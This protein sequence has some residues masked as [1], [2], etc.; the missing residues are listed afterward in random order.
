MAAHRHSPA[1]PPDV[2]VRIRRFGWLRLARKS[3]YSDSVV[4][5]GIETDMHEQGRVVPPPACV[6]R[7]FC[8][9]VLIYAEF[10]QFG[11]GLGAAF[12]LFELQR[13]QAVTDPFVVFDED[14]RRVRQLE[15][16]LPAWQ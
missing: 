11:I 1:T 3:G 5:A 6:G 2:R 14:P 9:C 16:L 15:V 13:P 10:A 7:N 8:R 4:V 12:P